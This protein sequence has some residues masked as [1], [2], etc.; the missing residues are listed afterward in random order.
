MARDPYQYFRIEARELVDALTREALLLEK[1]ELAQPLL[2]SMMRRAHTL[3]G[4]AGVVGCADIAQQS[5]A[6]E[7][8][9]DPYRGST[10]AVPRPCIEETLHLLAG[11]QMALESLGVA[12][13]AQRP[14]PAQVT[15]PTEPVAAETFETL[16]VEL[17]DMDALLEGTELLGVELAALE[18][19]SPYLKKARALAALLVEMPDGAPGF[20]GYAGYGS[21]SR[22]HSIARVAVELRTVLDQLEKTRSTRL[23][24]AGHQLGDVRE[25]LGRMR[26]G[27]AQVA[28]T[29]LESAARE[30]ARRLS[31]KVKFV[32]TGGT[33]RV[34]GHI[35]AALR[36][37]LLHV[38]RNA[39]AHGIESPQDRANAGKPEEGTVTIDFQHSGHGVK[40]ICHDDGRGIDLEA[41]RLVAHRRGVLPRSAVDAMGFEEA[42][43]L[44]LQGGLSTSRTVNEIS[45]RGVG[46]DVV[47]DMVYRF[48]GDVELSSEPGRGTTVSIRVPIS[49]YTVPAL[50]LE[51]GQRMVSLPLDA[52]HRT[53]L[54]PPG[55]IA[56]MGASLSITYE[57][58]RI[59]YAPLT[60]VLGWEAAP[61]RGRRN[62][63]IILIRS[64]HGAAAIG[65]DRVLRMSQLVI[66]PLPAMMPAV[67]LVA[68]LTF[69]DEGTPAFLLEAK[70]LIEHVRQCAR[71]DAPL[72][73]KA[74]PPV[75]V[76]DDSLT[77]R[78]LEQS[79]LESAG[80]EVDLATSGEQGMEMA[81]RRSYGLF[82]VDVEMPGMN[83]C[84]FVEITRR[85]PGL[86]GVPAIL[87]T[88]LG[89]PEQRGRGMQSGASAYIVKRE[90]DET[91]FIET[92]SNL[93]G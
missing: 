37:A 14:A 68:G 38:V 61:A 17:K 65:V 5:H 63:T 43:R 78:M 53:L 45:G 59:P 29:A 31:R 69:D 33:T 72:A 79:I 15:A 86:M 19:L 89:T 90:F 39:V 10:G 36:D 83:G 16:R 41:I 35:L 12:P 47:R 64:G 4:A 92:I 56:S 34:D 32:A 82:I 26:L 49:L 22:E 80:Y 8:A 60:S 57:G 77:T 54:L 21:S 71:P 85:D 13:P 51:A 81:R 30:A 40:V 70:S 42:A 24:Q 52:V 84:E 87:V 62:I 44:V 27:D 66:R 91:A 73:A 23:A 7:S 6:V 67:P 3:K 55:A 76:I 58:E 20:G 11:I 18:R 1:T 9:L 75:L 28:F 74:R 50:V 2:G 48:R 88:S 25:E 46:L 93:I